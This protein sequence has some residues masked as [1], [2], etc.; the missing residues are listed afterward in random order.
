MHVNNYVHPCVHVYMY[1]VMSKEI[2]GTQNT[3]MVS[4][5]GALMRPVC[6]VLA[7]VD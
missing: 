6:V 2:C 1:V 7:G 3:C 4:V 5:C